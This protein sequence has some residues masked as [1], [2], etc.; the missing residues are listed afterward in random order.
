MITAGDHLDISPQSCQHEA[1]L[2]VAEKADIHI[3]FIPLS[4]CKHMFALC[5]KDVQHVHW[6]GRETLKAN[7]L[8]V[9]VSVT[10]QQ[11]FLRQQDWTGGRTWGK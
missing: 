11:A 7:L 5:N 9:D 1:T 3:V 10:M 4:E 2:A 6:T 8:I